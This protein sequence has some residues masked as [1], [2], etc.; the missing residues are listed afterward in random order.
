MCAPTRRRRRA[1]ALATLAIVAL[2]WLVLEGGPA[3]ADHGVNHP[4]IR[5]TLEVSPD[6]G[7]AGRAVTLTGRATNAGQPYSHQS[8]YILFYFEDFTPGTTGTVSF[9]ALQCE[10]LVIGSA[11]VVDCPWVIPSPGVQTTRTVKVTYE[12]PGTYPLAFAA[13][14]G[15][16]G[17]DSDVADNI[18]E[19]PLTVRPA[20]A[21]PVGALVQ[22]VLLLVQQL[23][24][25][26]AP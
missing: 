2:P 8:S 1:V 20:P 9:N 22:Q 21:D 12:E 15:E 18:V 7:T 25:G 13:Q 26:I 6:P 11:F 4:D 10:G 19:R 24:G 3:R 14:P 16:L 5:A 17:V 23:L